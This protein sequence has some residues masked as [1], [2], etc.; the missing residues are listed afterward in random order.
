MTKGIAKGGREVLL[1][2]GARGWPKT[3]KC[4]MYGE[5]SDFFGRPLVSRVVGVLVLEGIQRTKYSPSHVGNRVSKAL[6][7]RVKSAY[8]VFI[9]DISGI[10]YDSAERSKSEIARQGAAPEKNR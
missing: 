8:T 9:H 2:Q 6:I 10:I 7:Y 1:L 5:S 3:S 4:R